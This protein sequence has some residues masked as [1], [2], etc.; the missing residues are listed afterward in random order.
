[1]PV[2]VLAVGLAVTS[3]LTSV[4]WSVNDH[5]ETRLL[6]LQVGEAG[7]VVSAAVPDIENPL[8]LAAD[9][10][11]TTDGNP[12]SFSSLARAY[13]GPLG[14]YQSIAL[15]Q[16]TG[17]TPRLIAIVGSQPDLADSASLAPTLQAAQLT[18]VFQVRASFSGT[19]PH[20]VFSEA[21]GATSPFVVDAV[22][23]IH[24]HQPL[25]V[26]R[27]TAFADLN[28]ALYLGTT[29][30]PHTLLGATNISVLP[31]RGRVASVVIPLGNVRLLLVA[32]P[33]GELGGS[34]LNHLPWIVAV[35]GIL[36]TIIAALSAEVLVRGRRLAE[37]LAVENHLLYGQQRD[38]AQTLQHALLPG[39]LPA[40]TGIEFAVRY[41]PG[42]EGV[43]IGG[44]WYDVIASEHE[45]SYLFAVGDVSGRGIEAATTM[46][47]LRYAIRAY[48][49]EG[50]SPATIL[51]KLSSL[52]DVGVD[53]Q[54]ATVLCGSV[55]PDGRAVVAS[56]GHLSPL[57]VVDGASHY[58]DAHPGVPVGVPRDQPYEDVELSFPPGAILLAF[59]DGLVER[60]GESIDVGL[61]RLRAAVDGG[62]D[63]VDV[64]LTRVLDSV[65][66]AESKDD[67][68]VLGMRWT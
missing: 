6:D 2:I 7:T 1:M 29:P 12:A 20:V 49:A 36:F 47:C 64:L 28:Y 41:L 27:N 4:C 14:R 33:V 11:M 68:A 13:V 19:E 66:V 61:E 17:G 59:T 57:V 21:S 51:S 16:I 48:A 52:L 24:P 67:T 42:A 63:S 35:L 25:D 56:A 44:D 43:D 40:A 37:Q 26:A 9:V 30:N 22:S 31:L 18:H 34:L 50:D 53:H 65:L 15:W 62:A 58:I 60:R 39:R 46:A 5:N 3:V 10:A 8:S 54:F 32:T 55:L 23:L 38:I 45:D